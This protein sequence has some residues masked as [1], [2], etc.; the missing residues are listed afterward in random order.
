[1]KIFFVLSLFCLLHIDLLAQILPT[2]NAVDSLGHGANKTGVVKKKTVIKKRDSA[3]SVATT[4]PQTST[5]ENQF[6]F[7]DNF[8]DNTNNWPLQN[9]LDAEMNI[10][11]HGLTIEGISKI[12]FNKCV[13]RF[14]ID[15]SKDF[16]C[17]VT[18]RLLSGVSDE[19]AGLCFCPPKYNGMSSYF[20]I[21]ADGYYKIVDC[22]GFSNCEI[23][24]W[25]KS[26]L[27][28]TPNGM[29]NT[30]TIKKD[31][32]SILY[33]INGEFLFKRGSF[34]TYNSI[35]EFGVIVVNAQLA[36]FKNFTLKGT[37]KQ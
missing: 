24:G 11:S 33:F 34:D 19:G 7:S 10:N 1:M 6:A 37:K 20:T 8:R 29:T 4:V 21:R 31:G 32:D 27:I 16:E 17:S 23:E 22:V 14:N 26:G 5:D 15:L 28:R 9:D 3:V 2:E 12:A 13:E 18:L 25:T 35:S 36:E 30:L